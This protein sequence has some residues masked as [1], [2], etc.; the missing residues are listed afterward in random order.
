MWRW[1]VEWQGGCYHLGSV[2][3]LLYLVDRAIVL[4]QISRRSHTLH[5][6]YLNPITIEDYRL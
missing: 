2:S 4:A 1:L 5:Q 6:K 3:R